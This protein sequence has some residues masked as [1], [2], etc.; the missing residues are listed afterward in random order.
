M[1]LVTRTLMF[2]AAALLVAQAATFAQA[3][4]PATTAAQKP[5]AAAKATDKA[6]PQIAKADLVDLNTATKE[7]LTALPGIGDAYAQKIIDGRPYKAKN[8]LVAKKIVPQA[9]YDKIKGLVI[10][11]QEPAKAAPAKAPVKK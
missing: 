8:Q 5:A 9:T 6:T 2:A 7:Q 11:K 4:K 1:K 3:T 10:A